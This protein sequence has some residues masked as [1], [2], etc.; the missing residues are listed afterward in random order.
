M[1]YPMPVD[2]RYRNDPVFASLVD[3]LQSELERATFTPSELREAVMFAAMLFEYR[4][5]RPF[6]LSE[7]PKR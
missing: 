2:E 6:V 5:V 3:L 1:E 4:H 7:I